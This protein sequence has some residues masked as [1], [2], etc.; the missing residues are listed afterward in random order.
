MKKEIFI[1]FSFLVSFFVFVSL[2][3]GWT[4]LSYW[5]FWVGGLVGTMLPDLD[6]LLYVFFLRPQEYVSQRFN[7][8]IGQRDLWGSLSLLAETRNERTKLIFHT[9][10]FQIIF[11]VFAF[12]V[13][14]SSGSVFG[15]GIVLAFMLH[16]IVDEVVDLMETNGLINWFRQT[17]IVLNKN[18]ANLY[19]AANAGILL[20]FGFLL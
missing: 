7:H 19:L 2:M 6:H 17:P 13:V 1:H 5:P 16:L 3:R 20:L 12:L 8:M 15:R 4:T 18:Q 14:T 9:A 10:L 11:L